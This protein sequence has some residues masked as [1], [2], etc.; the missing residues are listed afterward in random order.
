MS[1]TL[2]TNLGSVKNLKPL[3]LISEFFLDSA[4]GG[5]WLKTIYVKRAV[6]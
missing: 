5:S 3:T 2:A 6:F 1:F 4:S